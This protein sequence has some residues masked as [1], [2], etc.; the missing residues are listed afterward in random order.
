MIKARIAFILL[1]AVE[2]LL[3]CY[4]GVLRINDEDNEYEVYECD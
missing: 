4:I 3:L 1:P 2:L